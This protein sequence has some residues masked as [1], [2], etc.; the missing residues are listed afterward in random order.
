[1]AGRRLVLAACD[2][3]RDARDHLGSASSGVWPWSGT[4]RLSIGSRRSRIA[5]TVPA[6]RIS[7]L[8]PRMTINGTWA[9]ASN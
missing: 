6:L 2:E 8:A 3:C 9:S 7:E 4:S 5:A 1:M